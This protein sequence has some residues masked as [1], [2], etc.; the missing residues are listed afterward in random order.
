MA[1][2]A[3]PKFDEMCKCGHRASYHLHADLSDL[4]CD[5]CEHPSIKPLLRCLNFQTVGRPQRH[6]RLV[7]DDET[8]PRD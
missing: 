1:D 2:L 6:L 3:R 7:G 8:A 4:H 5:A